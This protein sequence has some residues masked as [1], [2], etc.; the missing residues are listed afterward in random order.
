MAVVDNDISQTSPLTT[1]EVA[2]RRRVFSRFW[3][4]HELSTP[5]RARTALETAASV[6]VQLF[7]QDESWWIIDPTPHKLP[8]TLAHCTSSPYHEA[9]IARKNNMLQHLLALG[10]SPNILPLGS[11]LRT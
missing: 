2:A 1:N 8:D 4:E 9:I 3:S 5:T 6:D 7:D 10:Y 11:H